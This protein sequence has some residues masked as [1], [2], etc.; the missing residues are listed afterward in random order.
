MRSQK[1][2]DEMAALARE[3]DMTMDHKVKLAVHKGIDRRADLNDFN[4]VASG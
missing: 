1:V 3:R 2:T 4:N